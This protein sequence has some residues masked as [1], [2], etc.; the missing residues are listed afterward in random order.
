MNQPIDLKEAKKKLK[1]KQE[2]RQIQAEDTDPLTVRVAELNQDFSLVLVGDKALILREEEDFLGKPVVR[3]LTL[4]A[5]AVRFE[6][7][8]V[9]DTET[10]RYIGMGQAWRK[11]PKRQTYDGVAFAPEGVKNSRWYNLWRGFSVQPAEPYRDPRDHYRKHFPTLWEHVLKNIAQGNEDLARW[12]W[13][14]FADMIQQPVRKTGTALVIRGKQ[15]SG[16]SKLGEVVGSLLAPHWVKVSKPEHLTGQFNAHMLSCLLLQADEG[17][18]AGDKAAE[19]ALKDLVSSDVHFVEKK[20]V[21]AIPIRNLIRLYVT[22]NNSWVVPAGFEER[23]FA[24]LDC[25][26]GN[27]QDAAFFARIDQEMDE[28]GREHLLAYLQSFD[29]TKVNLRKIPRT[30]ALWEQKIASMSELHHWWMERLQKGELVPG[31]REWSE[32]VPTGRLYDHFARYFQRHSKSRLPPSA[33]WSLALRDLLPCAF[34]DDQKV[35]QQQIQDGIPLNDSKGDPLMER[36]RGWKNFP[37]LRSCRAHFAEL[38]GH[39]FDWDG[40]AETAPVADA[41]PSVGG[42]N[43]FE[44]GDD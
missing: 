41:T 40:E 8:R 17:F 14:W 25:G 12:V 2:P 38:V 33:Q 21:D 20:G 6:N 16:K 7:E 44:L 9:W 31:S 13:A 19:G 37:T 39:D 28:G 5:F 1:T 23:R 29:L 35:A 36:V 10:D 27:M 4:D 15:G 42:I 30:R 24:V 26:N 43:S 11:H 22:S 32:D 34:K 18:W 3:F